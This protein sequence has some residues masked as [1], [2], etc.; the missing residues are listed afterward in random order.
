MQVLRRLLSMFGC[1]FKIWYMNFK[2]NLMVYKFRFTKR[3]NLNTF[4]DL[5]LLQKS[6]CNDKT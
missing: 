4:A 5:T 2:V 1:P 6:I 3:K